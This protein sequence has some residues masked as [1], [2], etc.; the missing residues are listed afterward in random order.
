MPHA[1]L[2][3]RFALFSCLYVTLCLGL[4][5]FIGTVWPPTR[6]P[7]KAARAEAEG[8]GPSD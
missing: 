7:A 8:T 3:I 2:V 4:G 1:D 5:H 6:F